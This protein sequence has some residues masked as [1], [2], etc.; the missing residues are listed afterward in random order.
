MVINMINYPSKINKPTKTK[1]KNFGNRGMSLEY[2]LNITNNYYLDKDI[3]VIYKKPTPI[4]VVKQKQNK[5][6]D[7]YFKSPSTTDYNGVYK[8]KY[9]DF[10]A[11][12]TTNKTAFPL[13]NIHPHQIKHIIKVL[14]HK[15]ICFLIVRFTSL[16]KTYYLPADKLIDF[17]KNNQRK[18]IPLSY[19]IQ[20]A[21]EIKRK[22][23]PTIDYLKIID[24]NER[25]NEI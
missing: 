4:Q 15:G 13:N 19:F 6:V 11:E 1:I 17:I 24:E 25:I 21:Y 10:E 9:I 20:N 14:D 22:L 18:S 5:I 23:N 16:D 2:D 12:E 3:A 8:G 7:A